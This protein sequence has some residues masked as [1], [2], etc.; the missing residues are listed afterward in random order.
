MILS[1]IDQ[2]NKWSE[3]LKEWVIGASRNEYFFIIIFFG[4]LLAIVIAY[5]AIHRDR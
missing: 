3:S 1:I 2:I 4:L 5:N